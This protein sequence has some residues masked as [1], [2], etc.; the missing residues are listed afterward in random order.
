RYLDPAYLAGDRSPWHPFT[1]YSNDVLIKLLHVDY[2]SGQVTFLLKAP[3]GKGLGTHVHHGP[4]VVFTIEGQWTYPEHDWVAGP[5]DFI[6][7][8]ADSKHTFVTLPG[9]D[10]VLFITLQGAL[11]WLSDTGETIA[12]ETLH[13]WVSRYESY[14]QQ[15]ELE[16]VDLADFAVY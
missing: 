11:Q 6:Q 9:D 10:V 4:V 14:C 2:A 13:S 8:L 15:Q 1:P 16:I 12:I 5:G 3:G 7:E